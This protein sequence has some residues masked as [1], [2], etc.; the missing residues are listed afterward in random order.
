M[1]RR[2][3]IALAVPALAALGRLLARRLH[4]SGRTQAA[5]RVER[6]TNTIKKLARPRR[7]SRR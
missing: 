1:R 5:G 3:I 7:R 6:A 4:A 2:I